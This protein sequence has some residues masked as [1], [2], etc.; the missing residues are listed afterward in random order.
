MWNPKGKYNW[1]QP[2]PKDAITVELL[3]KELLTIYHESNGNPDRFC[4]YFLYWYYKNNGD[5]PTACGVGI[6]TQE[7]LHRYNAIFK[8]NNKYRKTIWIKIICS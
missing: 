2:L 7:N 3:D 6:R 4:R 5:L 1:V 8:G